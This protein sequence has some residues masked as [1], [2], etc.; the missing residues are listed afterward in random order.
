M[1]A[2]AYTDGGSKKFLILIW[3]KYN[4]AITEDGKLKMI[5]IIKI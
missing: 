4:A 1:T 5:V 2:G 3:L